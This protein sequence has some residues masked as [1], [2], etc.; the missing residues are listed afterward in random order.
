MVRLRAD[1]QVCEALV[2]RFLLFFSRLGCPLGAWSWAGRLSARGEGILFN[3][4]VVV[5]GFFASWF[6]QIDGE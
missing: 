3:D 5:C 6:F 4:L 1:V 2:R